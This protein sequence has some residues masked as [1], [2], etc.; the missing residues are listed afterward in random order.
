MFMADSK[1][2]YG[3]CIKKAFEYLHETEKNLKPQLKASANYELMYA[4]IC[5][6]WESALLLRQK[7][8]L[9]L[10]YRQGLFSFNFPWAHL[11]KLLQ[12]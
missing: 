11:K 10:M 1:G 5:K 9:G 7:G 6:R 8:E 3:P 12:Q 2:F 4:D